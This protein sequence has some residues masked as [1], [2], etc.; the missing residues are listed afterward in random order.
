MPG[1]PVPDSGGA[2]VQDNAGGGGP[3]SGFLPSGKPGGQIT[4]SRREALALIAFDSED[5]EGTAIQ[6]ARRETSFDD[7]Q[8]KRL[9]TRAEKVRA[10]GYTLTNGAH[11]FMPTNFDGD[12]DSLL[13]Q[14]E[15]RGD[16][17][18][19]GMRDGRRASS[20]TTSKTD[21]KGKKLPMLPA[22][23]QGPGPGGK[24]SR[25][26]EAW[27]RVHECDGDNTCGACQAAFE[28]AEPARQAYAK[29][30]KERKR[31]ACKTRESAPLTLEDAR[32]SLFRE[33]GF[34]MAK[35]KA[36]PMAAP[37]KSKGKFGKT[38][39]PP[40]AKKGRPRFAAK[41]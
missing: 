3:R 34:P 19:R 32:Y 6:R 15:Q 39:A 20:A 23:K 26:Q 38:S 40:F 7:D 4:I 2:P 10:K 17:K 9:K 41:Y 11:K 28:A 37:K 31:S 35:A 14:E 8:L 16:M 5:D 27:S 33:A 12:T 36:A 22:V 25:T 24:S 29:R 21:A 30:M 1:Y 18:N 13:G